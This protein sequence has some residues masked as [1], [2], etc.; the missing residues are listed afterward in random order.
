M[1]FSNY[2][3]IGLLGSFLL[4]IGNFLPIISVPL[5]GSFNY[6]LN[7]EGGDGLIVLGLAIIAGL[8]ILSGRLVWARIPAIGAG[9][10]MAFTLFNYSSTI[11]QSP[12]GSFVRLEWGWLVLIPGCALVLLAAFAPQPKT[13]KDEW[14]PLGK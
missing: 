3:K 8:C 2:Q 13:D 1:E 4:G 11:G 9:L 10:V 7:G 6:M 14:V 12:F 5:L